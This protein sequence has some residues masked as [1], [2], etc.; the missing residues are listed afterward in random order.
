MR[1]LLPRSIERGPVEAKLLVSGIE[2]YAN[3]PRSIERGPVEAGAVDV[4][5]D[6]VAGAFRAQLS[7]APLKQ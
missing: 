6:R 2:L 5:M 4:G 3:L 1:P 7:A